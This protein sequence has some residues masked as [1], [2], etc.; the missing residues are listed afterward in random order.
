MLLKFFFFSKNRGALD[1]LY[2][3]FFKL[4][5]QNFIKTEKKRRFIITSI[6]FFSSLFLAM[7]TPN[8]GVVIE[9]LGSLASANVFIF[10]SLCLIKISQRTDQKLNNFYKFIF[11]SFAIILIL[12]GILM[13][14]IVLYQGYNDII[15]ETVQNH[16]V[17]CK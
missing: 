10:P 6:W 14:T 16:E 3:E 11:Y 12:T 1:G 4:S 2:A 17:L 15:L 9:F 8:I 13:F 5:A 7:Y